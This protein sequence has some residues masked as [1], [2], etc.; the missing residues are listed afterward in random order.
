MTVRTCAEAGVGATLPLRIG[1]KCGPAS[2][3]P[4]DVVATVKAFV[5]D[6]SQQDLGPRAA[7]WATPSGSRSAASMSWS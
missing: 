4:L 6:H 3:D 7:P 2:G 1:G 5:P